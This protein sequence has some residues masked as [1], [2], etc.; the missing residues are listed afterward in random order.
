VSHMVM[1][2]SGSPCDHSMACPQVADGGD[3]LQICRVGANILNKQSWKANKAW[4]SRLGVGWGGLTTHP[5]RNS[6]MLQNVLNSLRPE[7][8][9]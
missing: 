9:L 8:I 7:W 3:G 6:T 2:L 4:A 5:H 1:M